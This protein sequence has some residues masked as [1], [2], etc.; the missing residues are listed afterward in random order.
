MLA[1]IL[2]HDCLVLIL[3]NALCPHYT[4]S[5]LVLH[6]LAQPVIHP[7][8]VLIGRICIVN[9]RACSDCSRAVTINIHWTCT[10]I[11]INAFKVLFF[12]GFLICLF[13]WI[14]I[15]ARTRWLLLFSLL[16]IIFQLISFTTLL[17]LLFIISRCHHI[18]G[19]HHVSSIFRISSWTLVSMSNLLGLTT[20]TKKA[21]A[22]TAT[23][24]YAEN[25][26]LGLPIGSATVT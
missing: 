16:P 11:D 18:I 17:L 24:W 23:P 19:C 4:D 1:W 20:D 12:S 21:G 3:V 2:S 9:H 6:V 13:D 5:R 7:S 15:N 10:S 26:G 14:D 22:D 25:R 8:Q